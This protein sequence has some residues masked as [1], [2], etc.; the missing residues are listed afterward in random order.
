M[1]IDSIG[2]VTVSDR[3]SDDT[4]KYVLVIIDARYVSLCATKD[5]T[6]K[7]ALKA[8]T[9]WVAIFGCPR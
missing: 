5:T 9:D 8:L 4:E 7:A 3:K 6:A 2:P 1:C